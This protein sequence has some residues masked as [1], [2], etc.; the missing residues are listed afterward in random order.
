MAP[1]LP[2]GSSGPPEPPPAVTEGHTGGAPVGERPPAAEGRGA[3]PAAAPRGRVGAAAPCRPAG[4]PR[5]A[6]GALSAAQRR[7][8]PCPEGGRGRLLRRARPGVSVRGVSV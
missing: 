7:G 1:R 2:L 5:A 3:G 6:L 4:P 8:R